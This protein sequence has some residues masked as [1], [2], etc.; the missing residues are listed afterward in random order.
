MNV[1]QKVVVI[2]AAVLVTLGVVLALTPF[3][4]GPGGRIDC[5][6][7]LLGGSRESQYDLWCNSAG[8]GRGTV[9]VALLAV[10]IIGGGLA[11]VLFRDP[12]A[13]TSAEA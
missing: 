5:N 6:N 11:F 4:T 3:N 7:I 9:V 1:T 12:R 13:T 2:S 10:G 8:N